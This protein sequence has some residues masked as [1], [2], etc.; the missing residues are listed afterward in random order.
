MYLPIYMKPL[1]WYKYPTVN[2]KENVVSRILSCKN[3]DGGFGNYPSNPSY[4]ETLFYASVALSLINETKSISDDTISFILSCRCDDGGFGEYRST[5]S[6]LFNTFYAVS[7]LRIYDRITRNVRENVIRYL[8]NNIIHHDGIYE[9]HVGLENTTST[10]WFNAIK[11]SLAYMNTNIDEMMVTYCMSCYDENAGLFAAVPNGV[12]TIQ[13]TYECLVI[14]KE[15]Y[16]L[17]KISPDKIYESIMKRKKDHLFYDDLL[18]YYTFSTSMWAI[19]SLNILGK[20]N[21]LDNSDVFSSS[22]T[23]LTQGCSLYD[24][25][26][27]VNVIAN[28]IYESGRI[29]TRSSVI[30]ESG[31]TT[32]LDSINAAIENM[33]RNGIDYIDYDY[34][35]LLAQSKVEISTE[36]NTFVQVL[37]NKDASRIYEIEYNERSGLIYS[38]LT[39]ITRVT[40]EC[41]S[42]H[43]ISAEKVKLLGVF[44]TENNLYYSRQE[45]QILQNYCKN[46]NVFRYS[47][48]VGES[49]THAGVLAQI[50]NTCHMFYYSGHSYDGNL[51]FNG[52]VV[53]ISQMLDELVSNH[54]TIVIFNCCNTYKYVED[55]FETHK[56]IN[57][58][59]NVICTLND[60]SDEQAKAFMTTLFRYLELGYPISEA[61][62]MT[63]IDVYTEYNGCGNTWW[64]YILYGNPY[65]II[66]NQLAG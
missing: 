37:L 26:C 54:C 27:S 7:S 60:V 64:S 2:N 4:L 9:N 31:N 34:I 10:F 49:A 5:H 56:Y 33:Y 62:R 13:N 29:D 19:M 50:Q 14:L 42:K 41:I 11:Q 36:S 22:A 6:N 43:I 35:N 18:Q 15:C 48:L 51:Y 25:F 16:S 47:S 59:L 55:Y 38:L 30:E 45:E 52:D 61:L 20:L 44:D 57:E 66:E 63:R 8:R 28:M 39:P 58:S 32:S 3:E 21:W 24:T 46:N 12:P 65:T 17:G 23:S 40:S 53:P 1:W